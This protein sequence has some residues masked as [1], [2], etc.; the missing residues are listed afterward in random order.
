EEELLRGRGADRLDEL[1][2][3]HHGDGD[4]DARERHREARVV[5]RHAEVAVERQRAAAGDRVA[6]DR[7]D[8]R[9]RALLEQLERVLERMRLD[10][11]LLALRRELAK[12]ETGA[13]RRP[14]PVDDD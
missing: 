5:G 11:A 7:G 10:P 3:E 12:I 1:P 6:L 13:E 2:G 9:L 4:A 8:G 14:R